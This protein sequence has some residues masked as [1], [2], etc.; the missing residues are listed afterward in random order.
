[1]IGRLVVAV[2]FIPMFAW[3]ITLDNSVYY[4]IV[5]AFGLFM[6]L[7]EYSLM[8]KK[9]N[10]K[11][12]T[13][14]NMLF[15]VAAMLGMAQ[16][17][18]PVFSAEILYRAF[19]LIIVYA[20]LVTGYSL[21]AKDIKE[22]VDRVVFSFFGVFYIVM[23]GSS[24]FLVRNI[25]AYHTLFLFAVVWFY[26][27]GAYFIGSRFG[28]TKLSPLIS[29][30]K[31]L[32]GMAGGIVVSLLMITIFKSI[33]FTSVLVPYN[34]MGYAYL[35]VIILCFAAQA[36]DL[37]ESMLKRYCGVKDSSNLLLGHGGVL[38]KLDSFLI[39]TPIYLLLAVM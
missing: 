39:A 17:R 2:L 37:L 27:S 18:V 15:L 22:S 12:Y 4:N 35:I 19:T 32:E 23:L 25:G 38:D 20:V 29:P 16:F 7:L 14:L 1:M 21:F 13:L 24:L 5:I 31:S 28:K 3:F 34:N 10:V 8:M 9:V 36:G 26:D 11:I 30:K 6:G 33:K